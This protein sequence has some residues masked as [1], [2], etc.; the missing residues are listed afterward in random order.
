M[1]NIQP[2][3]VD[4]GRVTDSM[5][6]FA[7][8]HNMDPAQMTKK[9]EKM[10]LAEDVGEVVLYCIVLYCTALYC[11]VF[12]LCGRQSVSREDAIKWRCK[13]TICCSTILSFL[14]KLGDLSNFQESLPKVLKSIWYYCTICQT[15]NTPECV[16]LGH[17]GSLVMVHPPLEQLEQSF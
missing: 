12:R 7:K 9:K 5:S 15:I 2:G 13:S 1:T 16:Q 11:I 4:P 10:L 14:H 3:A 8:M 6:E 17:F